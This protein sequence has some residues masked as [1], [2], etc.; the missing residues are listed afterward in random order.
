MSISKTAVRLAAAALTVAGLTVGAWAQS[1]WTNLTNGAPSAEMGVGITVKKIQKISAIPKGITE[2]ELK[3]TYTGTVLATPTASVPGN[4][5]I[6]RV[7]TNSGA[8]D[9]QLTTK[10]GGKLVMEGVPTKGPPAC[11]AGDG[12]DPWNT[13]QCIDAGTGNAY[14]PDS[15]T[16]PGSGAALKYS[17]GDVGLEIAIGVADSG[18]NLSNS[19]TLDYYPLGAPTSYPSYLPVDVTSAVA[20]SGRYTPAT[21]AVNAAAVPISFKV[22]ID[23]AK[24]GYGP[25]PALA[26]G[27]GSWLA[28]VNTAT[29]LGATSSGF[30]APKVGDAAYFYVNVGLS[31]AANEPFI[32]NGDGAYTETLYFDLVATF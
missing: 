15:V 19:A 22:W 28:G 3:A 30:G 23:D 12:Y 24:S 7:E 14:T 8:W 25:I 16:I 18:K 20:A 2:D 21:G 13:S 6:V 4:L 29:A 11:N 17:G 26:G 31:G 9:V 10:W 5:G 32:G 1:P 27:K